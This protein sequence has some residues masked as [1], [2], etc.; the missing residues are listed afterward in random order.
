MSDES[1]EVEALYL[2][3]DLFRRPEGCVAIN[4]SINSTF[5][6]TVW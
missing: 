1:I 3:T 2:G 6:S 4:R 5:C